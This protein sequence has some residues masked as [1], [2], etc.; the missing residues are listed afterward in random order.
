MGAASNLLLKAAVREER[1][2]EWAK[3]A[4]RAG[5]LPGVIYGAGSEA[6]SVT[7]D[8]REFNLVRQQIL[9]ERVLLNVELSDGAKEQVFIKELQRDPLTESLLHVDLLRVDPSKP[10]HLKV[11]VRQIGSTPVGVKEGGILEHL[12]DDVMI[13]ALPGDVPGHI[14]ADLSELRPGHSYHVS[15]LPQIKGVTY[16]TEPETVLFAVVA[17]SKVADEEVAAAAA[18][19][20]EGATAEAAAEGEKTEE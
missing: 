12:L 13:E 16:M 11:R 15:D 10:V 3:K 5:R 14:D 19:T 8:H 17:K 20:A 18:A 7:F 4:R 2:K 9:G 6:T 1:G